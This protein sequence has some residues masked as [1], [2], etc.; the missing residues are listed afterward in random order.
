MHSHLDMSQIPNLLLA[1]CLDV[2]DFGFLICATRTLQ[3]CPMERLGDSHIVLFPELQES[4]SF[5]GFSSH[6]LCP[7]LFIK[8][9]DPT[10]SNFSPGQLVFRATLK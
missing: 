2:W 4:S 6:G 1:E 7:S 5:S 3:S 10:L 8:C 9:H